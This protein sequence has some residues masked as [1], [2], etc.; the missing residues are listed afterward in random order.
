MRQFMN[1]KISW[2]DIPSLEGGGVEW[3]FKPE[4]PLGKR[5][6]I[7]LIDEDIHELFEEK[8]IIV[9]IATA[10]QNYTG[11]LRDIS[12]GGLSL[13]VAILLETYLPIKVGLFLGNV[14]II[15]K[16]LVKHTTQ[17]GERYITGIQFVDLDEKSAEYINGLH[18]SKIL[19]HKPL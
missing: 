9:T 6:F 1:S 3:G 18:A 15:S 19:R 13:N 14:K 8:D 7:R 10:K 2:N 16:G 17:I 12:K 11:R 5:S 4:S